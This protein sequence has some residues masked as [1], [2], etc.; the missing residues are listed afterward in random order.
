MA[1]NPHFSNRG[2]PS[3]LDQS[4]DLIVEA[5]KARGVEVYYVP[6]RLNSVDRITNEVVHSSF[7]K[8]FMIEARPEGFEGYAASRGVMDKLGF[9]FSINDIKVY[10]AKR[11]FREEVPDEVLTVP[12]RPNEGDLIYI[13]HVKALLEIKGSGH[14]DPFKSG[15]R[16]HVHEL[17]CEFFKSSSEPMPVDDTDFISDLTGMPEVLTVSTDGDFLVSDQSEHGDNIEF[18]IEDDAVVEDAPG[19]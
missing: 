1:V 15:G 16:I 5:I 17:S 11:R 2:V 4:E 3:E 14:E 13:P 12:G 7:E 19:R 10:I 18:E 9:A 8:A 6:R